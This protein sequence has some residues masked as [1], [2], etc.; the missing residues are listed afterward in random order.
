MSSVFVLAFDLAESWDPSGQFGRLLSFFVDF[1]VHDRSF[2]FFGC[3][4]DIVTD[5]THI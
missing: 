3:L 2:G 1:E 4:V 5:E